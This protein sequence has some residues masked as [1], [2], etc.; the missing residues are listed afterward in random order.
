M[1]TFTLQVCCSGIVLRTSPASL[2]VGEFDPT[3]TEAMLFEL[4]S[5][6]Q[7]I[8]PCMSRCSLLVARSVGAYVNYNNTADGEPLE[9][10]N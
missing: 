9:E 1:T 5:I 8:Y 3:V 6:G 10:L 2:Y 4:F 7:A